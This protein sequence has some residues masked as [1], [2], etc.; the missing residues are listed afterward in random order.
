M[1]SYFPNCILSH[2]QSLP[3]ISD[4]LQWSYSL[5]ASRYSII[6]AVQCRDFFTCR[7]ACSS[8]GAKLLEID[9]SEE[10][11]YI[12]TIVTS[13]SLDGIWVGLDKLTDNGEIFIR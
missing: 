9:T 10:F 1:Q 12:D 2:C 5:E 13:K 8:L 7:D 6:T 3:Y 11:D 4:P